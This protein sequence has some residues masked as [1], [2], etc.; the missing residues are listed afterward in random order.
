ML[1]Q[2]QIED[3]KN[4]SNIGNTLSSTSNYPG[5]YTLL[6]KE[7][8]FG[9]TKFGDTAFGGIVQGVAKPFLRMGATATN[10]VDSSIKLAKGDVAGADKAI[11]K[12]RNY[13]FLGTVDPIKA[14]GER[15]NITGKNLLDAGGVALELGSWFTGGA[16]AKSVATTGFKQGLKQGVKQGVKSGVTLGTTSG[17]GIGMQEED[18]TVGSILKSGA[19][20]GGT[21]VVLGGGLGGLAG[22]A[23][24]AINKAKLFKLN[25]TLKKTLQEDATKTL[26]TSGKPNASIAT[27]TLDES[28]NIIKDINAKELVRQGL[29][30]ADVAM[31][32]NASQTDKAKMLEMLSIREAQL[33]DKT[34]T[35]RASDV[36]GDSFLSTL[37]DIQNVNKSAGQ[38][39]D[40]VAN[41]LSGKTV[42]IQKPLQQFS[43]DMANSG[44]KIGETGNLDFT[45]SI[46]RMNEPT[47]KQIQNFYREALKLSENPDALAVHQ[48]KKLID[49]VVDYGKK[50]E[51]ITGQ[52]ERLLKN[53]RHSLDE[54]LDTNFPAY[55]AVNTTFS[56][57]AGQLKNVADV[58]GRKFNINSDF[59]NASLGTKLRGLMS[60]NA[61]RGQLMQA[62]QDAQTMARKYGSN[63]T[64]DLVVQANFANTLEKMFGSEAP[65]SLAGQVSQGISD[66]TSVA[67]IGKDVA[68]SNLISAALKGVKL[69]YD[70]TRNIGEK[71][72]LDAL[73]KVLTEMRGNIPLPKTSPILKSEPLLKK[74]PLK[75]KG[76]NLTTKLKSTTKPQKATGE[77]LKPK[78]DN[79]S[80]EAR[81]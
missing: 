56:E 43:G 47:Q 73:R 3:V 19:I 2:S 15:G 18:A 26:L 65:T 79:L 64:D 77:V 14:S 63:S 58:M 16:A 60:N 72:K 22:G 46:F 45:K 11:Q 27:K 44:I 17:L 30:E 7:K 39:L 67:N 75:G 6:N 12:K 9:D 21:G 1:T 80:S 36:A 51:G 66:V 76:V 69:V 74:L 24:G 53:F 20:G 61:S 50:S 4:N 68:N 57:T 52:T 78:V 35:K 59:A 25:Q 10:L 28:G 33:T 32:K 5:K 23:S 55:D 54:A 62:I 37:K 8:S 40:S 31:I 49:E 41:T 70:K 13:G 48:T 29:E 71:Q 81:K 38:Q 42:D 34:V